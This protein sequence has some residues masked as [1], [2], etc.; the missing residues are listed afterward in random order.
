[1]HLPARFA[2]VILTFIPVFRQQRTWCHAKVLLIGA[3]LAPGKRTVTSLLRIT[4]LSRERR[5]NTYHLVLNRAVWDL[6]AAVRLLLGLLITALVPRGPVVLGIDDTIERRRGKRIRAKGIYRD[7]VRSSK[8]HFVKASGLRWLSLMLLAPIPWAG[9]VW[10]LP[11]LTALAPSERYCRERGRRHKKLTDWAR[12]M[13]LQARRWLPGREI[14]LLGD[15]SFAALEL[16]AALAR[17]GLVCI[18][19][20]RLPPGRGGWPPP[21]PA[22]PRPAEPPPAGA[23][24]G[25]R[26]PRGQGPPACRTSPTSWR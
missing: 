19:R 24:R 15:G 8:G 17:H 7:P 2:A 16:L 12:Q 13:G 9:R 18:T 11:S 3:I 23:A 1:M 5:F 25:G 10:A 26:A 14:V 21:P 20:L 22:G 6:R 4:G